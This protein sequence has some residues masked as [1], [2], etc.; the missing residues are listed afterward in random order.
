MFRWLVSLID[1]EALG[2]LQSG[3]ELS[4]DAY[5][6]FE[7]VCT[8]FREIFDWFLNDLLQIYEFMANMSASHPDICS[9]A[10][11]GIH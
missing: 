10:S 3:P 11:Y 5:H 9:D 4:W 6:P 8:H 1:V 2:S 7:T